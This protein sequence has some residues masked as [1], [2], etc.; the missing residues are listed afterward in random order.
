MKTGRIPVY[1]EADQA[2]DAL[3]D[4][5]FRLAEALVGHAACAG[6]SPDV[7][8]PVPASSGRTPKAGRP[9]KYAE[10]RAICARCPVRAECLEFADTYTHTY[11]HG[12]FGGLDPDERARRRR[13]LQRARQ[14]ARQREEARDAR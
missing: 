8:F 6:V 1:T 10:A 4:R 9:D 14:R 12:M 13:A 5:R 3:I 7:F 11:D 2:R